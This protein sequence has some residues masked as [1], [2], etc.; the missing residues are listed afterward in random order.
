MDPLFPLAVTEADVPPIPGLRYLPECVSEAEEREL[1]EA[2][3]ALPWNTEWR[4]RRQS[5]GAGNGTS[6]DTPPIPDWGRRLADS[7]EK[8][9]IHA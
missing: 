9:S 7:P 3:D 1:V 8:A 5:Y 6:G 4:H 2:I